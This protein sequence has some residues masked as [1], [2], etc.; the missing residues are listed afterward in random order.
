MANRSVVDLW[1]PKFTA[2]EQTEPIRRFKPNAHSDS[3]LQTGKISNG[4]NDIE[5]VTTHDLL[6]E[7]ATMVAGNDCTRIDGSEM[8]QFPPDAM[9]QR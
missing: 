8:K 1:K 9:A 2:T 5:W 7:L 4:T 3:F 6:H